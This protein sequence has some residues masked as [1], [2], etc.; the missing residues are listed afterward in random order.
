MTD[1]TEKPFKDLHIVM[2]SLLEA[3]Q[4]GRERW[5]DYFVPEVS[6]HFESVTIHGRDIAGQRGVWATS[7]VDVVSVSRFGTLG[8]M[9]ETVVNLVRRTSA[10]SVVIYCGVPFESTLALVVRLLRPQAIHVGWAR[11]GGVNEVRAA[12]TPERQKHFTK[13]LALAILGR[14]Q[15]CAFRKIDFI[16]NGDD[17]RARLAD[18]V[19]TSRK[20][21]VIPNALPASGDPKAETWRS[22]IGEADG[23][24]HVGYVG[25]L[26]ATKGF[27]D[28]IDLADRFRESDAVQFHAWGPNVGAYMIPDS[29]SYHGSLEHEQ[30]SDALAAVDAVVFLN[31]NRKGEASGISHGILEAM[32]D[33]RII[34]AWQNPTQ[35]QLLDQDCALLVA[36]GDHDQLEA[37]LKRGMALTSDEVT[38]MEKSRQTIVGLYSVQAHT[39]AFIDFVSALGSPGSAK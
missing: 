25:R 22:P 7:E 30:V 11:G 34:I 20:R 23:R 19:D 21:I 17:T 9:I 31:R 29:I 1:R 13:R 39:Q 27:D 8:F 14:A 28:Y 18:H 12:M 5:L 38:R 4:G 33:A 36:E 35:A 15:V 2:N 37:A 6:R 24:F 32:R 10:S 26:V 16:F 3:G